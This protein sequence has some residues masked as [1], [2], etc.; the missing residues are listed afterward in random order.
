MPFSPKNVLGLL[1]ESWT[2][3][4]VLEF[5]KFTRHLTRHH[6]RL[7]HFSVPDTVLINVNHASHSTPHSRGQSTS[8]VIL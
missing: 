8:W 7:G 3:E 4:V 6:C 1:Q 2:I 5:F